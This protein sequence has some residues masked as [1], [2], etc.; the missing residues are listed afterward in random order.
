MSNL[1]RILVPTVQRFAIEKWLKAI[2]IVLSPQDAGG[3]QNCG[4]GRT[5]FQEIS[6]AI[7]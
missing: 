5:L 4:R 7:A 2:I 6:A 3:T 1:I